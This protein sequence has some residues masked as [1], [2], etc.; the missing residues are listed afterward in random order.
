MLGFVCFHAS[1]EKPDFISWFHSVSSDQQHI[2]AIAA[3]MKV[4]Y[5]ATELHILHFRAVSR[6]LTD[7]IHESLNGRVSRSGMPAVLSS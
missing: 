6:G 4:K 2:L 5:F 3:L 1:R 7:I